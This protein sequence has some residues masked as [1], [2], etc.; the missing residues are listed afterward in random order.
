VQS[1]QGVNLRAQVALGL[2]LLLQCL[3]SIGRTTEFNYPGGVAVLSID[4]QNEA[5]P[6]IKYGTRE[7]VVLDREGQWQ[8]LIGIS[9]QTLPGEYL[10]Y[11]KPAVK[12]MPARHKTFNVKQYSYPLHSETDQSIS[13]FFHEHETLSEIAFANTQQPYLP[14]QYPADGQWSDFFGHT[15]YDQRQQKTVA[16]N[17][18]SLTTTELLSVKAPQNAIVTK[19]ET[20][21]NQISTIFLDHGRGLYSVIGG[22]TDLSINTGNGVVAGAVIGKLPSQNSNEEAKQLTWQCILNGVYVNPIILTQL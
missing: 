10:M 6:E 8:V 14:L 19:I 16:Q 3:D 12:N 20:D 15:V 21:A 7:P 4:K 22:V 11:I 18:V 13:E 5:L 2:I 9:L 1:H 17:L